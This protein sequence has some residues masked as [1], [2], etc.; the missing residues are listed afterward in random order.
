MSK[1]I[2]AFTNKHPKNLQYISLFYEYAEHIIYLKGRMIMM[3]V[4]DTVHFVLGN[5]K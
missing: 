1:N 2:N 3:D 4:F 5:I